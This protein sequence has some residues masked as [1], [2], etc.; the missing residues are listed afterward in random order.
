MNKMSSAES[1]PKQT[2]ESNN[3]PNQILDELNILTSQNLL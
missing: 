3:F 2:T 1:G